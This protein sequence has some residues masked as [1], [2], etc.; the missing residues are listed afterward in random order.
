MEQGENPSDP[1]DNIDVGDGVMVSPTPLSAPFV[2]HP[3]PSYC[4]DGYEMERDNSDGGN[5]DSGNNMDG[6]LSYIKQAKR[7]SL[8]LIK[9]SGALL[10]AMR[11]L[12]YV[13]GTFM[14]ASVGDSIETP[15]EEQNNPGKRV[16]IMFNDLLLLTILFVQDESLYLGIIVRLSIIFTAFRRRTRNKREDI[17][18]EFYHPGF[19]MANPVASGSGLLKFLRPGMRP[20][21]TDIQAAALWGVTATTAAVWFIQPFDWLKKTL[22]ERSNSEEK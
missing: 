11:S 19:G 13:Y 7:Q 17:Y 10:V 12:V 9:C 22:F 16:H 2:I 20:Q 21:A 3:K 4:R 5:I 18:S 14:T 8:I 1:V 15:S 6:K